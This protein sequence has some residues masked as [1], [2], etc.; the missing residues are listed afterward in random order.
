MQTTKGLLIFALAATSVAVHAQTSVTATTV[1]VFVEDFE[2]YSSYTFVKPGTSV[3]PNTSLTAEGNYTIIANPNYS[4]NLYVSFPDH[5]GSGKM[6][7]ANGKAAAPGLADNVWSRKNSGLTKGASYK[8]KFHAANVYPDNPAQLQFR[9]NSATQAPTLTLQGGRAGVW[10]SLEVTFTAPASEFILT[11]RDLNTGA[12]G[13][14][15]AIDDISISD[16]ANAATVYFLEKLRIRKWLRLRAARTLPNQS[17]RNAYTGRQLHHRYQRQ[18]Q[19]HSVQLLPR[20]YLRQR[21]NDDR[22]RGHRRRSP[23]HLVAAGNRP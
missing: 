12:G 10:E 9:V 23:I 21:K 11:I 7:V 4:H 5:S 8:A 17:L 22:Q 19:P 20:P 14:D 2:V 18:Q 1:P 16:A 15:F 13:N 6:L 3:A